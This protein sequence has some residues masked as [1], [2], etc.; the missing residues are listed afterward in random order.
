MQAIVVL[1]YLGGLCAAPKG[2][3]TS[4]FMLI[5]ILVRALLF[6]PF[7]FLRPAC[8][9]AGETLTELPKEIWQGY[10]VSVALT[11]V[12]G[13]VLQ[14]APIVNLLPEYIPWS[15]L[16]DDPAVSALGHDLFIGVA[17]LMLWNMP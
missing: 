7:L 8:R 10:T 17:G 9:E 12:G 5:L 4:W 16:S 6:A 1:T 3:G 15:A 13:V 11:F 14:G 2:P